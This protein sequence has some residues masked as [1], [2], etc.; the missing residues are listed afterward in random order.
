MEL[1]YNPPH[2]P[3]EER[4]SHFSHWLTITIL[5][6]VALTGCNMPAGQQGTASIQTAAALTV[7]ARL[8]A[9]APAA[10]ATNTQAA[11]PTL[12][13]ATAVVPTTP[14]TAATSCDL[15]QFISETV[16]D[17]TSFSG[18]DAFVKTW[19][20]KNIGTCSWTPSYALV[21]V[22]GDAMDGPAA[23]GL[24]GNVNPGQTV[25][26]SVDLKAP[27]S[28]GTYH[29]NWGLR[30][31]AG[32]TF[33]SFWVQI[34]VGGGGGGGGGGAFAVT[35]VEA[36][37]TGSCPNFH[38]K[39]RVTTNG[40]GT[41][42]YHRVFSDGGTDTLPGSLDFAAAGTKT[43]AE[44]DRFFGVANSSAWTDLYIDSPNHQQFGRANFSCP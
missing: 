24:T 12:P 28:D 39:F 27:A 8:T 7:E 42:K 3:M 34:K 4:M 18:D 15:A 37:V 29:G 16:P 6:G 10:T 38:Y 19:T 5:A 30:N 13:A 1:D 40:P 33:S 31:A 25:T 20:L 21:F 22:S 9:A 41:V 36:V 32:V 43:A 17:N 23:V 11:F 35:H 2:L 44:Y 14:P 26:V